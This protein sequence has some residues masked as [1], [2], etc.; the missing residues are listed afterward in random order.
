[1]DDHT[2]ENFKRLA[3]GINSLLGERCEAV[4]HDFSDIARSLVHVSG[5]IT[6]R[7]VGAPI[8]DVVFRMLNEAGDDV[9]DMPAFKT[10]TEDGRVLRCCT[11]FVRD[12]EGR[13]TGSFGINYDVT[14]FIHLSSMF[15]DVTDFGQGGTSRDV[16]YSHNIRQTMESVIDRVLTEQG[17]PAAAMN[18]EDRKEVVARLEKAGVFMIKGAVEYLSRLLGASR[19]TIYTYLKEVREE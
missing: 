10:V 14:D 8:T 13:V 12:E 17:K 11:V 15:A 9:A 4:V 16:H 6:N 2:L 1:M 19:Y 5:N 7:S 18:R 3:E